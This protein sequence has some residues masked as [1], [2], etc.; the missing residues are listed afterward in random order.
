MVLPQFPS[1]LDEPPYRTLAMMGLGRKVSG[2][3][4]WETGA[5]Q[6]GPE[7][8]KQMVVVKLRVPFIRMPYSVG[9]PQR[10]FNI[11]NYSDCNCKQGSLGLGLS[12]CSGNI[13]ARQ[14]LCHRET[15]AKRKPYQLYRL[16][17]QSTTR[18]EHIFPPRSS[19]NPREPDPLGC[20]LP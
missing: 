13:S 5:L 6:R 18:T 8:R 20:E 19:Q 2:W 10:D 15:K 16:Q 7:C 9:D 12:G 14:C 11:H 17:I 4:A 3:V 1:S